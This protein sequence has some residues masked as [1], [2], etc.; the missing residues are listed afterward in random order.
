[1]H[2]LFQVLYSVALRY[3]EFHI[4]RLENSQNSQDQAGTEMSSYLAALGLPSV[5]PESSDHGKDQGVA[6]AFDSSIVSAD[7]SEGNIG[8]RRSSMS[9]FLSLGNENALEDWLHGSHA[10][11]D[12][13]QEP[14]FNFPSADKGFDET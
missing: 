6:Q 11:L 13:V 12:L 8:F 1:M 9:R 7:S 3:V 2:H 4:S 5:L 10:M 14:T